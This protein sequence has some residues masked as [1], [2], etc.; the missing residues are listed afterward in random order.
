MRAGLW[1]PSPT[2]AMTARAKQMSAEGVNVISLAAGEPD[3][4]THPLVCE[5]ANE[6]MN[7]GLT[8]Y[9]P[10]KGLPALRAAIREKVKRENGFS[11]GDDQIVVSCGA[12]HSLF[13]AVMTLVNPGDEVILFAPYWMTYADQVILAGG[14]PIVVPTV[15]S[16]G[17]SPDMD[18]L[19]AAITNRTRAMIVNTPCNPTGGAWSRQAIKE[20]AALAIRHDIWIISD[21]IYEHLTY[22]HE[23]TSFASLSKDVADQTVTILGCSK[24]YSMT[25]WR[26]GFSVSPPHVAGAMANLQD[27]VTSNATSFAQAGAVA[28]LNLPSGEVERMRK[29]FASRRELGLKLLADV[30]GVK[31]QPPRG[32]FY[33]FVDVREY[34]TGSINT[35]LALAE[36]LLNEAHVATVPGSVFE[37]SGHLRLSY[38]ASDEN[39]SEGISRISDCLRRM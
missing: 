5:A 3:F 25:G 28:A 23:H 21:E 22:G 38:A 37:G 19:K 7:A 31:V 8:K 2:L 29:T 15:A 24:S 1:K 32:A 26:I 17:Y 9:V 39:I 14:V 18:A 30:P 11:C 20:V 12:K 13:N 35:D 34:L 33:F 36:K 16:E 10:S 6:A 4:N 27:Q